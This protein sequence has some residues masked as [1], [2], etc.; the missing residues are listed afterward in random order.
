MAMLC[1]HSQGQYASEYQLLETA[2]GENAL[3]LASC[4]Q[5]S[6]RHLV[7]H[8]ENR[9]LDY[10]GHWPDPVVSSYVLNPFQRLLFC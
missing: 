1:L 4:L 10:K 3:V 8:C 7:S 9:M 2:E 6:H 5:A